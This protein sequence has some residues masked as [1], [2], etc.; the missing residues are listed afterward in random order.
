MLNK[1]SKILVMLAAFAL[2]APLLHAQTSNKVWFAIWNG[3]PTA[4]SDVAV[5]SLATSGGAS[6]VT[7]A[8]SFVSQ[9]NFP[10]FNSPYD[11]AVDPVMGKAYVLDNDMQGGASEYIYSFNLAG[12]PAQIAQSEQVI[13]TLPVPQADV[14]SSLYPAISGI[15]LDPANHYLY[16]NQFDSVTGTNS[17]VGRL[18]LASSSESDASSSGSG[19]PALQ[20]FYAGQVPGVGPI[21][22]DTTNLYLGAYNVLNGTNGVYTAPLSGSGGFTELVTISAGDMTFSNGFISGVASYPQSNLVYYLTFDGGAVNHNYAVSQNAIWTYNTATH[23]TTLVA[24]NYL[25]YPDNLALDPANKRYYFTVGQDGTGNLSPTNHQAI[26]TGTLGSTNAPTTL[27]LPML[28]GQ[29]VAGGANAGAVSLQGIFIQD[30]PSLYAAPIAGAQ[31]VTAEKNL[32]LELPVSGLIAHDT[33]PNGGTLSLSAVNGAST[34]GGSV[35]LSGNYVFYTPTTNFTGMDQFTYTLA[36]SEGTQAQ[37]TINVN[38]VS[39]SPPPSNS[40]T[41]IGA[42]N[43][44]F[45][46]YHNTLGGGYTFEYAN[47]LSGP[48]FALSPGLAPQ[49]SGLIEFDD[50]TTSGVS[51]R[52]YRV[53]GGP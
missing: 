29:D 37:G 19:N 53:V 21:A 43:Q 17:F 4:S 33:D 15:A 3:Q 46:L 40:L 18:S 31:T 23:A 25:G 32:T 9:T 44:V 22:I 35:V 6:V 1:L 20:A 24:A 5:Q 27:Y 36:D 48:W 34:N 7:N 50:L 30:I 16:F 41:M 28:N 38:V 10:A 2:G 39:L 11:I 51:T 14:N 13:Y 12:T 47:S 52:F 49:T 8:L 45:L 42:P 26:Y